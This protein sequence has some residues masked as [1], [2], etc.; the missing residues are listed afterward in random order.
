ML[1][2]RIELRNFKRTTGYNRKK[3]GQLPE[4]VRE[5]IQLFNKSLEDIQFGNE[6]VAIIALKGNISESCFHD[7][8]TY[9]VYAMYLPEMKI[10]QKAFNMVIKQMTAV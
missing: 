4:N 5:S 10:R 3:S 7:A 9:W 2:A 8:I 1:N 6:D